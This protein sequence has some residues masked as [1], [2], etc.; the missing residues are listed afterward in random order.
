LATRLDQF[1]L[2]RLPVRPVGTHE[3]E[4]SIELDPHGVFLN[5]H[6]RALVG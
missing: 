3:A 6:L 5:D 2:A 1:G 4:A